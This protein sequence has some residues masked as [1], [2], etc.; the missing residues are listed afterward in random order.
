MNARAWILAGLLG[1]ASGAS[2]AEWD[3]GAD[4]WA[5]ADAL[6]RV[7]PGLAEAGPVRGDRTVAMFYF[8]WLG[9]H[10]TGGPWDVTRILAANP[11]AMT[12]KSSPPWGPMHA[13]HHWGE[14][15]FGYYNTDDPWVLAKHAQMLADAGVD[16]IVFDLSNQV[17]YRSN[18][19]ALFKAFADARARGIRAPR[20][21][22]LCPFWD[23]ARVVAELYRDVYAP[24]LYSDLWFR[25]E[26]KPLILA[27]PERLGRTTMFNK[28]D[29]PAPLAP[30][31]TLGQSFVAG[32]PFTAVAGNFPTW[33][34]ADA[35]VTLMLRQDGPQGPVAATRRFERVSD[36]AWLELRAPSVWPAGT[37]Y[38]EA[39][40]ATGKIG[41]WSSREESKARGSAYAGGSV[42]SGSRNLRLAFQSAEAARVREFFT[43]RAP[44]PD[45]FQGQT[46]PD[47]WSWL[48][49]YPQHVFTNA[50]GRREQMSVGVAQ[51]AVGRRLGSMSEPGSMGRSYHKGA[52]D[53][54][55]GAVDLGLNFSEQFEHALRQDPQALFI[56]GWNEWIMGRFDEFAGVR[57]P[58]MFVDEFDQER[59]RDI[60]PMR[61]GHGDDYYYQLVSAV[62]RFKGVRPGPR[63]GAERT[64]DLEAGFGAWAGV[65]PVYRDDRGDILERDWPGYNNHTRY[66]N[67]TGR[68]DILEA[69]TA[70]DSESLYFYVQ[71]AGALSATSGTNWM[72]LLIDADGDHRT[73]WEG[74][75]F[76]VNRSGVSPGWTT[77]ERHTGPGW[78]WAPVAKVPMRAGSNELAMAVSRAALGLAATGRPLRVDFKWA[79]NVP[80]GA[81]LVE[82]LNAGDCAPNGRLNYR[83]EE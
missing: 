39:G 47:M 56:T 37:Y 54:R 3:T 46:A 41:W 45:Y 2:A 71:T 35:C 13:S 28:H 49:V 80:A 60:E 53:T 43:F 26:G 69:R 75:D 83:F 62:R 9:A 55:P 32:E 23:P 27:D 74:Y 36:N 38:L 48:E 30:G 4:T 58:V 61:G 73:G 52:T 19:L 33:S 17:T 12:N 6:G 40:A 65:T 20:V 78:A 81:P 64:M 66:Q 44:Q 18:Y 24:G 70:R 59:S 68:N 8:L 21:A 34:T 7:A 15:L 5:G 63:A 67:R 1:A 31:A 42:V 29:T 72:L 51:N 79:D 76:I 57:H 50:A 16:A 22:F 77:L 14:P 25:W 11:G 10:V 82:W